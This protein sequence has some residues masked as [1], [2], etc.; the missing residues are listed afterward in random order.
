MDALKAVASD[1]VL[2]GLTG[3]IPADLAPVPNPL[4]KAF[5][6]EWIK[7]YG[8]PFPRLAFGFMGAFYA[9][10]AAVQKADSLNSDDIWNAMQ[11]LEYD[12]LEGHCIMTKRPDFG[13]TR[14][15]D[16]GAPMNFGRIIKGQIIWE[17]EVTAQEVIDA[18]AK[19]RGGVWQ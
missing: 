5:K 13:V 1:E 18:S 6:A 8:E 10:T 12:S 11:G 16:C 15:A 4:V 19:V 9:F 17:Y 2:E 3:R 14:F 7:E